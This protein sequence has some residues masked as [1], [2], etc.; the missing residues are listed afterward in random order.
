[1]KTLYLIGGTMGVGKTTISQQLKKDLPNC[2]FLDGDWCW[3]ADPF[4]VTEETEDTLQ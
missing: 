1:M 2:V 3:D 4:Q